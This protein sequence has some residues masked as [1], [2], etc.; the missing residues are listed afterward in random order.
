MP[1]LP[2]VQTIVNDLRK[3]IIGRRITGFFSDTPRIFKY[4]AISKI[5]KAIKGCKISS[6]ERRGKNILIYLNQKLLVIHP[7]LTG[8]L[9]VAKSEKL[10]VKKDFIRAIFYLDKNLALAFSDVRKFG[11]IIFGD[12]EKIEALPDLKNLGPDPLDSLTVDEFTSLIS[13]EK[14]NIKQV[15][16]DQ[17][18]IA[19]IGNIYSDEAL[20]QARIHPFT[21]ANCLSK[22]QLTSLYQAIR[23]VLRK[24]LKARGS[25]MRDYRDTE[26]NEG[27]YMKIRLVYARENLSC[28]RCKTKIKRTKMGVRSAHFCPRCQKLAIV[29]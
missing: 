23:E 4:A 2:E 27:G 24:S 11:K 3:K 13:S 16:L 25:S 10:N 14:R 15:L 28:F 1:E 6:V 5:A 17:E 8:R 21:P 12:R 20:W 19:G 9:L 7:K 26:G 22:N 18:V 29:P